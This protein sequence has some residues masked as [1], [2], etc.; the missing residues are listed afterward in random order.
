MN[1]GELV[2]QGEE[3]ADNFIATAQ[4]RPSGFPDN[5]LALAYLGQLGLTILTVFYQR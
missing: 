1:E 5:S 2:L 4:V 3:L